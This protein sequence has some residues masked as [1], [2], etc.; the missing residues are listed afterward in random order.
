L[1]YRCQIKKWP[2]R[3]G[4]LPGNR[5]TDLKEDTVDTMKDTAPPT[6]RTSRFSRGLGLAETHFEEITRVAPWVWSV[7]SCT[8]GVV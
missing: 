5:P 8:G 7:P 6:A 3:S 1:Q 4:E 2:R